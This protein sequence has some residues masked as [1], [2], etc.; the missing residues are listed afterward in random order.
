MF[1]FYSYKHYA[2]KSTK[3]VR[4]EIYNEIHCITILNAIKKYTENII[5]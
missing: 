5:V 1:A 3:D 2:E 4:F